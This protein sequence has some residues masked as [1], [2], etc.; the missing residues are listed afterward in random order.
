[1][2]KMRELVS[3]IDTAAVNSRKC[4]TINGRLEKRASRVDIIERPLIASR[5]KADLFRRS[6]RRCGCLSDTIPVATTTRPGPDCAPIAV[7]L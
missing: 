5:L 1:M 6:P 7:A 3:D 4:L 2:P